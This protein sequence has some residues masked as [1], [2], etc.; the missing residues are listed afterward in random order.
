MAWLNQ[1]ISV[2]VFNLRSIR[3]RLAASL[4]AV[5]G[6]AAVVGVF[7]GVLSMASGFEKTMVAAGS[8]DTAVLL[9]AGSTGELSSGISNEQVQIVANAPGVLRDGDTPIVSAELYVVVDVT[10]KTTNDSANVPLRGVQ[11]GAFGVRDKISLIEGRQ[12]ETGKLDPSELLQTR[13]W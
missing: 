12:F 3:Q 10:K 4:V 7:A 1:I 11:P 13:G 2:T 5:I 6:V 8:A 9:R